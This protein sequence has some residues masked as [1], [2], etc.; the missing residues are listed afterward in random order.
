M[1][2]L[3]AMEQAEFEVR[4]RCWP[5]VCSRPIAQSLQKAS[6][7]M[8]PT[9]GEIAALFAKWYSE[10]SPIHCLVP[11]VIPALSFEKYKLE[12]LVGRGY[13]KV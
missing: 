5:R 8:H 10:W 4:S 12:R 6:L 3:L 1:W 11:K 9:L 7:K 13:E 2:P